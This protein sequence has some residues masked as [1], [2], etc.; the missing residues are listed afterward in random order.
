MMGDDYDF[1]TVRG[2]TVI[3]KYKCYCSCTRSRRTT[4]IFTEKD[5]LLYEQDHRHV[6]CPYTRSSSYPPHSFPGPRILTLSP[7]APPAGWPG[8]AS[9]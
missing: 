9:N 3:S 7:N 8:Q 5:H 6:Y 2:Q 1:M 4:C